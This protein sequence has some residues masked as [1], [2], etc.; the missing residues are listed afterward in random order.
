MRRVL[1]IAITVSAFFG[2]GAVPMAAIEASRL[3]APIPSAPAAPEP[4]RPPPGSGIADASAGPTFVVDTTADTADAVFGNG[5]CADS[6]NDCSLRA[7][8]TEANWWPG[9]NRIEFNLAG[10]AP[11]RIQ[12][13]VGRPR[14]L[15]QDNSGG[16]T[17]DGY[18]QPGSRVNTAQVGSNAIMGVEI[19]GTK[20][21]PRGNALMVTSANNTIRGLLLTNH[22]RAIVLDGADAQNNHIVGNWVGFNKKGNPTVYRANYNIHINAGASDN[23]IGTPALADRNVSGQAVHAVNLYGAG[24]NGNIIQNNL[25]CIT[26]SGFGA[27]ACDIGIDH[28]HGPKNGLIG[29]TGP[30]ER[31]VIGRTALQGIEYSHGWDPATG[32]SSTK[33]QINNNRAIGNWVGFRGDGSYDPGFRSGQKQPGSTDN[34]NGINLHDGTKSNLI[35]GN[36]VASVYDGIQ[37]MS[38]NSTANIIRNNTIGMSPTG[39]AAPLSRYGIVAR[40]G[41]RSHTVEGNLI[42]NAASGGI[43][44]THHAVLFVR[45]SRNIIMD[46]SGPAIFLAPD[47][48]NPGIGANNLQPA[49]VITSAKPNAVAGTGSSGATVELYRASRP[50]GQSG[51][52]VEYLGSATVGSNGRWSVPVSIAAGTI[53]TALQIRTN[54]NTS[55]MGTNVAATP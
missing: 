39:Q 42:R 37:T 29:G 46:T 50:A 40:L 17:I 48:A 2:A 21:G 14:L 6:A 36:Y 55:A 13:Q 31:N 45:L 41:T 53:V 28:N 16:L 47:P 49:P 18:T 3:A 35:E 11:V 27:A 33:W 25:L 22:N 23:R 43:G 7:A 26:P 24:T 38:S 44:L 20:N 10:T 54:G 32:I 52:P 1:L 5:V 34:G 12:L 51:L 30:N 19:R 8:I 4:A 15:I 9:S